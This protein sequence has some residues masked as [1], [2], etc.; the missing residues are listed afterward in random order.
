MQ[1][2]VDAAKINDEGDIE[3]TENGE[4]EFKRPIGRKRA[5]AEDTKIALTAVKIM[6]SVATLEAQKER[7]ELMKTQK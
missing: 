7:Y 3:V 6:I 4:E 5:K 2:K 1:S